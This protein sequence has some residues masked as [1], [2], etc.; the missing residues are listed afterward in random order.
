MTISYQDVRKHNVR[1]HREQG[2]TTDLLLLTIV[3]ELSPGFLHTHSP[4]EQ[5]PP[6]GQ[7][8][9]EPLQG[10]SLMRVLQARGVGCM[11]CVERMGGGFQ[12]RILTVRGEESLGLLT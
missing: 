11:G 10:Q 9:G 3:S 1:K 7:I 2:K 8:E 5:P 12:N 6:C 4:T